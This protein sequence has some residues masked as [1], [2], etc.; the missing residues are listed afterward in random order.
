MGCCLDGVCAHES[1]LCCGRLTHEMISYSTT[2]W[3]ASLS[4]CDTNGS[5]ASDAIDLS[6]AF[7]AIRRL[8]HGDVALMVSVHA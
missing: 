4:A 8:T 5:A 3:K 2:H 1:W 7:S 6:T